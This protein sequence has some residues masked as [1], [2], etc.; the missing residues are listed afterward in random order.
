M[1][2]TPRGATKKKLTMLL[3]QFFE[4]AAILAWSKSNKTSSWIEVSRSPL[5]CLRSLLLDKKRRRSAVRSSTGRSLSSFSHSLLSL[6]QS[7]LY[8]RSMN[9]SHFSQ[10]HSKV[11]WIWSKILLF[12]EQPLP[13]LTFQT[14]FWIWEW[15]AVAE[16]APSLCSTLVKFS[17]LLSVSERSESH[18]WTVDTALLKTDSSCTLVPPLLTIEVVTLPANT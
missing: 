1:E 13:I 4:F 6:S 17:K 14:G 10:T 18:S 8:Q 7:E 2:V 12:K 9:G 3:R 11:C 15:V 16:A 5:P